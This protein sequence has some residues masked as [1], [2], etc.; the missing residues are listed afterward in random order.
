MRRAALTVLFAVAVVLAG[1]PSDGDAGGTLT[2]ADVPPVPT[3]PPTPTPLP[4]RSVECA[5]PTPPPAPAVQPEVAQESASVPTEDAVVDAT[6]LVERHE[7]ALSAYRYRLAA[8]DRSISV[9]ENRSAFQATVRT[10]VATISHYA[11]DG[12]R[13]SYYFEDGGRARYGVAEYVPA[14]STTVFGGSLS[15]TGGPTV[16]RVLRAYPHRVHTVRE[17]GWT[18]VRATEATP[19]N[20]TSDGI[21]TLNS[22]VVIDRRGI[23]RRV[24][25]RVA[26][27]PEAGTAPTGN[28]SLWITD[29]GDAAVERP[30]W[31]CTAAARLG[32]AGGDGRT[33][34][35]DGNDAA[36]PHVAEEIGRATGDGLGR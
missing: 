4:E 35:A 28:V 8:S 3:E 21:T 1:C 13:Y 31:V 29:L 26:T 32:T 2:P 6:E 33:A 16:E 34:T 30:D 11:I 27:G 7:S 20:A 18:V 15:V 12:T 36:R 9:T 17:N 19:A 22:T 25:T 5:V 23:V 10:S 24:E 14:P